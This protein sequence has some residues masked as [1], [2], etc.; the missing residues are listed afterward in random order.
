MQKKHGAVVCFAESSVGKGRAHRAD[1]RMGWASSWLSL[2]SKVIADAMRLSVLYSRR[3]LASS[4][5]PWSGYATCLFCCS[6][7]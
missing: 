5:I 2:Y 3:R 6:W 4:N 1:R 7:L